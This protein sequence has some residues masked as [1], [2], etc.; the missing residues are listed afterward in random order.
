[1]IMLLLRTAAIF[2]LVFSAGACSVLQRSRPVGIDATA[3][4]ELS[5]VRAVLQAADSASAHLLLTEIGRIVYP[6]MD[7]PIWRVAYRPFQADLKQVLVLAGTRGNETA[8][9]EY[10]LTLIE[11]LRS[12]PGPDTLYDLDIIPMA[13]P[14]GWV[15]DRPDTHGG[16]DIADDFNRFDSKEARII[17]RFLRDKRYDLVLDLRED[18]DATG[19]YLK[20]YAIGR[21]E[22]SVRIIDRLRAAGYPI[23]S[24]PDRFLLKPKNGIV[25]MPGWSLAVMQSA[26]QLTMAGYIRQSVSSIVFSVVTPANLP[27]ADRIVMQRVAAEAL[28]AEFAGPPDPAERTA[29]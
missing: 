22:T 12:V 26:R 21:I 6:G 27:L 3:V 23:E 8:G 20:Q 7:A 2:A 18:P 4:R 28:L 16:V 29:D 17:R 1:M 15:H 10:V 11:R 9:L 13:N 19:F 14:W 5:T 24:D 25:D